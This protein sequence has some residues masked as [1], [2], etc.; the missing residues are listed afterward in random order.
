V[1]IKLPEIKTALQWCNFYDVKIK[2]GV[3]ILYKALRNDYKSSWGF[4]YSPGTTPTAPDWDGGEKECG[5]GLNFCP[6]PVMALGFDKEATRFMA[7]PVLVK[8]IKVHK[9]AVYPNKIKAPRVF[10]PCYEVD[11]NGKR[12]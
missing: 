5:G 11:I 4:L 10:Q 8:E 1:L 2:K 7:C 6:L 12:I 3:V 9:N